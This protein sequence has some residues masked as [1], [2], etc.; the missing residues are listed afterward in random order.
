MPDLEG[1]PRDPEARPS[2]DHVLRLRAE[3][4]AIARRFFATLADEQL[5]GET[6]VT[7]PGY[8]EA[9][10]YAV[11]RCLNAV[12]DEE[13]WHRRFAERDLSVL[14]SRRAG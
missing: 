8:P 4:L 7:G 14:E 1:V 9:G 3:R 2:L 11:T 10:S 5:V 6:T 13:W 12:L